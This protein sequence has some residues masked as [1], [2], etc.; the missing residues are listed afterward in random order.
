MSHSEL[1]RT[2]FCDPRFT[3]YLRHVPRVEYTKQPFKHQNSFMASYLTC[4]ASVIIATFIHFIVVNTPKLRHFLQTFINEL[5][6]FVE[7]E[8]EAFMNQ[9]E[10]A[11]LIHVFRQTPSLMIINSIDIVNNCLQD[12]NELLNFKESV[13]VTITSIFARIEI[14]EPCIYNY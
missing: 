6:K 7:T 14:R 13:D 8:K 12:E 3:P 4:L 5:L 10:L 2:K 9:L 1:M 11:V